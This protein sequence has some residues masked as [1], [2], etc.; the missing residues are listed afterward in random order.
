MSDQL[1]D[2][3]RLAEMLESGRITQEE[4]D[5][6]KAS[7]LAE[8]PPGADGCLEPLWNAV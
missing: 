4:F 5:K 8:D 2:L 1:E 7:L 3:K 6:L